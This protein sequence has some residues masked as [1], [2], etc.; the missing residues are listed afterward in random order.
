MGSPDDPLSAAAELAPPPSSYTNARVRM[1]A[2]TQT[3]GR[4]DGRTD[5]RT[6]IHTKGHTVKERARS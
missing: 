4:T 6:V 3:H 5:G 1:D 2:R